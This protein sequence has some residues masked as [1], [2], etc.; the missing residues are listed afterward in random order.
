M[1][2]AIKNVSHQWGALK[3]LMKG[4]FKCLLSCMGSPW[5]RGH[6]PLTEIKDLRLWVQ[7]PAMVATFHP[8]LQ[9]NSQGT[10]SQGNSNQH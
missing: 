8:G 10:P 2:A 7:S 5:L 9:K 3:G 1:K 4:H 6:G